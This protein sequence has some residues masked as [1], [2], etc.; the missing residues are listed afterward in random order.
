MGHFTSQFGIPWL[1]ALLLAGLVAVPVGALVAIPAIRLSGV[2]LALATLG[3]GILLEQVFYDQTYMFSATGNGIATN[4]PV[5]NIG[6]FHAGS[7]TGFFFVVLIIVVVV[8][9]VVIA[10]TESRLGRLLRAMGD[11][12]LALESYGL[13]VNDVKIVGRSSPIC[14]GRKLQGQSRIPGSLAGR[15]EGSVGAGER[16]VG[17]SNVG[18]DLSKGRVQA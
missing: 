5:L 1:V 18:V 4:R 11:S 3:F 12:P 15:V 9:V 8:A 14:F 16:L 6:P 7:D 17:Q 2:F 10:I 13:S